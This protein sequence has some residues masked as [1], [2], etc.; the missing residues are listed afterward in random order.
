MIAQNFSF[1]F[2]GD[3]TE[4]ANPGRRPRR[5]G[6]ATKTAG[7]PRYPGANPTL[8][9]AAHALGDRVRPTVPVE[10]LEVE[11]PF[12]HPVPE[13]GI[14]HVG[15]IAVDRVDE[16]P[17]DLL[18]ALQRDRLDRGVERR[19]ARVLARYGE[20]PEHQAQR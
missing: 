17:G 6:P 5:L 19:R 7:A 3:V 8:E 9:V 20:V 4:R 14:V 18:V 16:P 10:A 11:P 13:V 1:S 15:L 12:A 2:G